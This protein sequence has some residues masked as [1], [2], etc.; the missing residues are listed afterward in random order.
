MKFLKYLIFAI[1][2]LIGLLILIIIITPFVVD[3]DKYKD[4]AAKQISEELNRQISIEG[5]S[6]SVFSGLGVSLDDLN[7]KDSVNFPGDFISLNSF[8]IKVK[9]IPLIFKKVEVDKIILVGPQISIKRDIN[10]NW[11][12]D[13]LINKFSNETNS[14][15]NDNILN[16]LTVKANEN[17][18][19]PAK[20]FISKLE[21]KDG[22]INFDDRKKGRISNIENINILVKN[23]F[24]EKPLDNPIY[25]HIT[26]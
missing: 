3:M 15:P 11:N 12:F 5:I 17:S 19:I 26:W 18:D 7:I 16:P 9:I 8:E 2:G 6:L 13:D 25:C 1:L 14:T 22:T 20:L 24:S 10:D 23:L 21:I 4:M